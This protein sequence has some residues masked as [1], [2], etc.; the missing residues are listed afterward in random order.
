M[1]SSH[2]I[3]YGCQI[4]TQKLCS[5]TDKISI[6]QKNAVRIM[7]FSDFNAHSE[8]LFKKMDILKFKDNIVLQNC[9]FVY[10]YLKGN[11][12][13]SFVNTFKR[14]DETHPTITRSAN[15]GQLAIPRYNSTTYGLKSIYKSCIDSWNLLTSEINKSN[16]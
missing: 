1:Q 15:T 5:V 6:L 9:I 7:T 4:W 16:C 10:D 14:V 12:P 13:I 11:L 3:M 2:H 8:P